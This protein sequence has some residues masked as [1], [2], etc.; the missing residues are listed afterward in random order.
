MRGPA[1][2]C[3]RF[4]VVFIRSIIVSS[5]FLLYF[6]FFFFECAFESR[7][8]CCSWS[9]LGCLGAWVLLTEEI[10]IMVCGNTVVSELDYV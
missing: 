6:F 1:E 4:G 3:R 2:G 10:R 8:L 7:I 9:G 5:H